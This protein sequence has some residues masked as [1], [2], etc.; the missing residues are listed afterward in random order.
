MLAENLVDPYLARIGAD[1]IAYFSAP[2]GSRDADPLLFNPFGVVCELVR[3]SPLHAWDLIQF[4]LAQD[5]QAQTLDLLSA[6]P[7]EDFISFHGLD[8]IERIEEAAKENPRFR[9]LL[10]GAWQL[11]TPDEI[12][13]R[14]LAAR[15]DA[16]PF[17]C[18]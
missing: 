17:D 8:W 5:K 3:Q 13:G 11:H 12:W 7:L 10:A 6:G 4:I 1:W 15:G 2:E 16:K 9:S 14:V 18:E